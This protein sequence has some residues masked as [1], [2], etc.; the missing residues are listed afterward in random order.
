MTE[1]S[2][3]PQGEPNQIRTAASTFHGYDQVVRNGVTSQNQKARG[4]S[5]LALNA[6][7]RAVDPSLCLESALRISKGRVHVQNFTLTLSRFKRIVVV[8]VGKASSS[9]MKTTLSSLDN[10]NAHGILIVPKGQKIPKFDDRVEIF[11]AGHPLPD[12][13]GEKAAERVITVAQGMT[14]N[15]LLICLISG[16]AS[17]MLPA[18]PSSIPLKDKTAATSRLI[19]SKATIHEINTVRRHL[20]RI[21][22]GRLAE[23]SHASTIISFIMSDVTGNPLHDIASGP[24]APDPTTYLD[25]VQVLKNHGLWQDAPSTVKSHLTKGLNHKLPDTPKQGNPV[26][27]RVHNFVIADSHIACLGAKH[28]MERRG[29]HASIVSSTV[30]MEAKCMAQLLASIA[31]DK[32]RLREQGAVIFGGETTVEVHGNGLGGRNQ[33]TALYAAGRISGLDGIAVAAMGTDGID[34]HSTAAGAIVDGRTN[35][36]ARKQRLD[37][38]KFLDQNDSFSF[39][40]KLKDN[41]MTGRTGTNVGDIYL[42]V[43][44]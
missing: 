22:G 10:W 26:F 29:I 13:V 19:R 31:N 39:F 37:M 12:E 24:T 5:L 17:A 34:G 27:R 25:A 1:V 35:E 30:D 41:L 32:V 15:E 9:M 40:R 42:V 3:M 2:P 38:G 7:L 6:A 4:I 36:R 14:K 43:S 18:P 28:A 44:V 33:E 8:A 16:G 23:L 20:S 11:F 21:K